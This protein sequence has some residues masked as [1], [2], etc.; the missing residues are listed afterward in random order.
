MRSKAKCPILY[1]EVDC[2][3]HQNCNWI[4]K[5][6]KCSKKSIKQMNQTDVF[7]V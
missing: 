5:T 7:W 6:N 4:S 3:L 1:N 2:L